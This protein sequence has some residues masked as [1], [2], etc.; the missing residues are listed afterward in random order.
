MT[1]F[2]IVGAGVIAALHA[3][4]IRSLLDELGIPWQ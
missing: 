2:G 3:A 1:G 4:A